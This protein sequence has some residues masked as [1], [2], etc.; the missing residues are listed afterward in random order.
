MFPFGWWC[1]VRQ[2]FSSSITPLLLQVLLSETPC[3]PE[4]GLTPGDQQCQGSWDQLGNQAPEWKTASNPKRLWEIFGQT[5]TN[6]CVLPRAGRETSELS[7]FSFICFGP[8][9]TGQQGPPPSGMTERHEKGLNSCGGMTTLCLCILSWIQ[10]PCYTVKSCLPAERH[11]AGYRML[12]IACPAPR[13]EL[14]IATV[15]QHNLP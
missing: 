11:V 7:L 5:K 10:V 8:Q 14:P 13:G 2:S 3:E 4:L 6:G 1:T 9:Q 15:G 12:L